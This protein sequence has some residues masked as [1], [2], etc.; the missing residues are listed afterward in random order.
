VRRGF[1][2]AQGNIEAQPSIHGVVGCYDGFRANVVVGRVVVDSTF[3]HWTGGNTGTLLESSVANDL[4]RYPRNI[5]VWLSKGINLG[6][7]RAAALR[8]LKE[9]PEVLAALRAGA[10]GDKQYLVE[11]G[12]VAETSWR[13]DGLSVGTLRE[14]LTKEVKA[15]PFVTDPVERTGDLLHEFARTQ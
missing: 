2:N 8:R 4:L 5:A 15:R 1:S 3:H 12:K 14:L 11:L 6:P 10:G 9:T 7:G 13:A